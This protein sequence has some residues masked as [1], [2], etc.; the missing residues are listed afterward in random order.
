MKVTDVRVTKSKNPDSK[1]KATASITI[2]N[3]FAVHG[4]KL[5]ESENNIFISFPSRRLGTGEF[6]DIAHPINAE[7]R[8][9][10]QDAVLEAYNNMEE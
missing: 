5:I 4:I 10:I 7:T 6:V 9:M 3:E 2:D 8:S 1:I